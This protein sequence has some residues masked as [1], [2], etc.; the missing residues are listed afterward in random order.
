MN[1]DYDTSDA[2]GGVYTRKQFRE[3]AMR[4][5]EGLVKLRNKPDEVSRTV[6]RALT[7]I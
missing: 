6:Q 2:M 1:Y 3:E 7:K 4:L 5:L